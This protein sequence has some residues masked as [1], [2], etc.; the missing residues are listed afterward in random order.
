MLEEA[1]LLIFIKMGARKY[2]ERK[3]EVLESSKDLNDVIE[4]A[5]IN[6]FFELGNKTD[7]DNVKYDVE[8]RFYNE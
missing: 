8:K 3:M 6:K 1:L 7:V 4:T 2:L 5:A